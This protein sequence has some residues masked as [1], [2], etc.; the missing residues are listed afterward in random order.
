MIG[1]R[2]ENKEIIDE[3]EGSF[4]FNRYSWYMRDVVNLNIPCFVEMDV[5]G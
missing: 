3:F 5:S 2:T 1:R 4:V